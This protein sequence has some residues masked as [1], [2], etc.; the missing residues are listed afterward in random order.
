[1]HSSLSSLLSPM[2]TVTEVRFSHKKTLKPFYNNLTSSTVM[3]WRY[4]RLEK[5]KKELIL[6]K[7]LSG[8]RDE[9]IR[10]LK[11]SMILRPSR[12][13]ALTPSS[14]GVRGATSDRLTKKPPNSLLTTLEHSGRT[15]SVSIY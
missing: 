15:V 13:L 8:K 11:L 10:T 4:Q 12:S 1:M 2:L 3:A 6:P 9:M 7:P 5:K 14:Q